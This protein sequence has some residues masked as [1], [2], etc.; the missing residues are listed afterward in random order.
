VPLSGTA[1][2]RKLP[3]EPCRGTDQNGRHE[4]VRRTASAPVPASHWRKES[5]RSG[6]G[7]EIRRGHGATSDRAFYGRRD[8]L[9][10]LSVLVTCSLGSGAAGLEVSGGFVDF[11]FLLAPAKSHRYHFSLH[12]MGGAGLLEEFG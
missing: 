10:V 4:L 2:P 9:G 7:F 8:L 5:R 6:F 12:E 1:E 11:W 3:R